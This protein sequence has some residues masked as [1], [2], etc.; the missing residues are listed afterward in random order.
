MRP[1]LISRGNVISSVLW[2]AGPRASMR[3]RLI[4]RGNVPDDPLLPPGAN[5]SMRPRLISRGNAVSGLCWLAA[6]P[7]FNEAATDQSRKYAMKATALPKTDR[8]N[9]AATDQSRKS[10]RLG[11]LIQVLTMLQ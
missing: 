8:F 3:P 5:A 10:G 6:R 4:S 2:S 1:R 9:E 11:G 7:R